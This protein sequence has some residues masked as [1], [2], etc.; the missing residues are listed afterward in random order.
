MSTALQHR[1]IQLGEL[2]TGL[3]KS[4]ILTLR[5]ALRVCEKVIP[6]DLTL[7]FVKTLEKQIYVVEFGESRMSE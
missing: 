5:V 4:N 1:V 2:D 6:R 7:P 3:Y